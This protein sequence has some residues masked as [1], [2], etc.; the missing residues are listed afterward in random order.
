MIR[1]LVEIAGERLIRIQ[2][3]NANTEGEAIRKAGEQFG[4]QFQHGC[5]SV[6]VTKVIE[7]LAVQRTVQRGTPWLW[8]V[9]DERR[10]TLPMMPVT[11]SAAA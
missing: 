7:A 3:I 10:P 2:S 8:A 6:S 5:F 1:W 9:V 11:Q 4:I